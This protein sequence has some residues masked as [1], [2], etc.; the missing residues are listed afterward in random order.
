MGV[1]S[2]CSL[3]GS[4]PSTFVR[5]G[6]EFLRALECPPASA[7]AGAH[8]LLVVLVLGPMK[9]GVDIVVL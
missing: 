8:A 7:A 5:T 2:R 3:C 6:C 1:G 9:L 4:L